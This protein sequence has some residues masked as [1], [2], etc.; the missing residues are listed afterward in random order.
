MRAAGHEC[1][2]APEARALHAFSATLGSRSGAKFE[3]TGWSRGYLL[4]RYGVLRSPG[5]ALRA[6]TVES[7]I[8]AG[9]IARARTARGLRG[10]LRGWRDAR[11][12]PRLAVPKQGLVELSVR[13][14]LGTRAKRKR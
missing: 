7:A 1:A 8:C 9:Q 12:L 10:R 6:L 2:L 14:R 3:M 5:P 11:G 13:E 4:G